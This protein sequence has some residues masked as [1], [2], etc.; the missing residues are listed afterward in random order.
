VCVCVLRVPRARKRFLHAY[1]K[2]ICHKPTTELYLVSA[3]RKQ[4]KVIRVIKVAV[5]YHSLSPNCPTTSAYQSLGIEMCPTDNMCSRR[6]RLRWEVVDNLQSE[7][8]CLHV[9]VRVF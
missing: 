5:L 2:T 9:C 4:G 3:P 8:K 6:V 7:Q 1:E